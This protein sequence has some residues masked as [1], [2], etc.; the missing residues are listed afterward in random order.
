MA[1]ALDTHSAERTLS[2]RREKGSSL[3]SANVVRQ[4]SATDLSASWQPTARAEYRSESES[5][6]P[7]VRL[8]IDSGKAAPLP[9]RVPS[10]CLLTNGERQR[11]VDEL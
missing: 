1:R 4:P 5:L 3:A 10:R 11:Y 7:S 2:T 9:T 8:R 6:S